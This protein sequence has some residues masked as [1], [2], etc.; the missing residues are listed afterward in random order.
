MMAMSKRW[1]YLILFLLA[2]FMVLLPFDWFLGQ[3]RYLGT[4]IGL[5]TIVIVGLCLVMGYTGQ[6]SLGQAAFFGTGMYI[7]AILTSEY[8]LNPW[9]AMAIAAG[10]TAALALILAPI[11]KLRGNYLALATLAVGYIVWKIASIDQWGHT[12]GP[13]GIRGIPY[14]SIGGLEFDSDFRR[15][16]LVWGICFALLLLSQNIVNSRI[17]R[18]L[19]A[20]HGNED[21]AEA[22]GINILWFKVKIFVIGAVFASI[23]GSLFA[24][25]QLHASPGYFT[26]IDSVEYVVMAVVGGLASIWGAIFGTTTMDFLNKEVLLQYGHWNI[27]IEGLILIV[28]M[29]LY[30]EGLF[31]AIKTAYQQDGILFAPKLL[32]NG[33]TEK[34]SKIRHSLVRGEMDNEQLGKKIES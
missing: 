21:A 18:A 8:N 2:I 3:Y 30:P 1:Q 14:L 23:A 5:H 32:R 13:D 26:P 11:F 12:G 10:G 24:H 33:I 6:V 17:G 22:L 4:L 29:M 15:Y 9:L 31:V 20:V 16:F 7:S 34:A 19:R 28:I 25:H 27:A